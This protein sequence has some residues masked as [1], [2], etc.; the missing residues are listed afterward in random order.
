MKAGVQEAKSKQPLARKL[1]PNARLALLALLPIIT[2]LIS[3]M[4]GRYPVQPVDVIKVLASHVLPIQHS[5]SDTV[6]VVVM[7]IRL[8]RIILGLFVGAA[9]SVAGTSFQGMFRNPLVSPDILGVSAAAGFGAA[10]AILLSASPLVIQL[11]ALVFGVIGV[12]LAYALSRVHNSTSVVMLVLG[13]VIIASLFGALTSVTKYVADPEQKLPAI[14]FWLLGGLGDASW[15]KVAD[16]AP[17]FL[18]GTTGL[19]L[20]SWQIN[21]LAMGDEEAR[22]LGV[23]TELLKVFVVA[24]ATLVTAAAVSV[25]GLIGW[26]GLVI[27]HVS[28]M[29]VG[30]DH[31]RLLPASVFLGA[32]FLLAIDNIARTATAAEIPLGILT[33]IVGTPFFAYLLRRTKGGWQ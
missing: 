28:R 24:C 9:L 23:R 26:V 19:L 17:M 5:W 21:L 22:A 27:P 6:D 31:R 30:P 3:F 32:A 16:S 15:I 20:V 1:S 10:L 8:P 29:I 25:S 13:G 33:A 7:Q 12:L 18:A 4:L 2:F 14:T 11:T